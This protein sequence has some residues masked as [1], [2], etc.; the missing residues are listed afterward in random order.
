M[1]CAK[2]E[3]LLLLDPILEE[4]GRQARVHDLPDVRAGI[5]EPDHDARMVEHGLHR[6][7]ARIEEGIVEERLA[8]A[9]DRKHQERFRRADTQTSRVRR[10]AFILAVIVARLGFGE[11][12]DLAEV[13]RRRIVQGFPDHDGAVFGVAQ[14]RDLGVQGESAQPAPGRRAGRTA[15]D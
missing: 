9:L 8:V 13:D 3:V 5:A 2:R 11:E 4:V 1:A 12:E 15:C 7:E 10:E 6:V 14:L